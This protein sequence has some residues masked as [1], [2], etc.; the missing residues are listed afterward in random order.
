MKFQYFSHQLMLYLIDLRHFFCLGITNS[1]VVIK[2]FINGDIDINRR[3]QLMQ[4]HSATH[5]INGVVRKLFGVHVWQHSAFKNS[6][7]ARLDITHYQ[8]LTE[9]DIERIEKEV[10]KI[11]SSRRMISKNYF[12]R[13]EAEKLIVEGFFEPVIQKIPSEEL[14]EKIRELV[15]K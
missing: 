7:K 6:E 2:L 1:D 12:S 9:E 8:A 14:K 5:L 11:I 13:N 10:N 15:R 3:R 4:H